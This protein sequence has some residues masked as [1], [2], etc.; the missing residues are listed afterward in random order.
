MRSSVPQ[1]GESAQP[2]TTTPFL[3]QAKSQVEELSQQ[4]ESESTAK[5]AAETSLA[6]VTAE[7]D[8]L[9]EAKAGLEEQL[10]AA[11]TAQTELQARLDEVEEE[12]GWL[13]F[14]VAWFTT[15]TMLGCSRRCAHTLSHS[16]LQLKNEQDGAADKE[17]QFKVR[18]KPG[19]PSAA[20]ALT[21]RR[22]A[23]IGTH[24]EATQ[25]G[26]QVTTQPHTKPGQE[27][28]GRC[29]HKR[30]V[31][32]SCLLQPCLHYRPIRFHC[33]RRLRPTCAQR[34]PQQPTTRPAACAV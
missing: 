22:C 17:M 27:H 8:Q 26:P 5:Q 30:P 29:R 12:V 3:E 25:Q 23:D 9:A 14:P 21:R 32:C 10:E 28:M 34:R 19:H 31:S 7:R 13:A 20:P 4:V 16:L 24:A 11:T 2:H 1:S 18:S 33:W 15:S 6:E